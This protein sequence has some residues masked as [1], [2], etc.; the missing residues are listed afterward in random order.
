MTLDYDEV[1]KVIS[2]HDYY[3]N[4]YK[5]KFRAIKTIR[6]D[7]RSYGKGLYDAHFLIKFKELGLTNS[8][9]RPVLISHYFEPVTKEVE[10]KEDEE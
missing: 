2:V 8:E 6:K 1:I 3:N 7:N 10:E 5:V 9:K 4:T